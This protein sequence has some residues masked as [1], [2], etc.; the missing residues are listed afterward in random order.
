MSKL[1]KSPKKYNPKRKIIKNTDFFKPFNINIKNINLNNVKDLT[2]YESYEMEFVL[3]RYN[4]A[5]KNVIDKKEF[6][7]FLC[8]ME[9]FNWNAKNKKTQ[10]KKHQDRIYI[11]K[12]GNIFRVYL[13][14]LCSIL[15]T[16]LSLLGVQYSDNEYYEEFQFKGGF[17]VD[18]PIFM[19]LIAAF[20]TPKLKFVRELLQ[21]RA[22]SELPINYM[23]YPFAITKTED[24]HFYCN[25]SSEILDDTKNRYTFVQSLIRYPDTYHFVFLFIDHKERIVEFYDPYMS[26]NTKKQIEFTYTCLRKLFPAYRINEFW[27]LKSIQNV[28]EIEK[29]DYAYCVIWGTMLIHLKLLNMNKPIGEIEKS[30]L[31]H[32]KKD[33]LSIYE[34][35]L[36]Y[37]HFMRRII[38]ED[39]YKFYLLE[40]VFLETGR[41]E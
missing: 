27:K 25:Y 24:N 20:Q 29:D 23:Y 17:M 19:D 37:T 26:T 41:F 5:H 18:R 36:N 2:L 6:V 39:P 9:L 11:I 7:N 1:S 13:Q 38:P 8:D 33:N 12:Y 35:M 15:A 4:H 32:C 28:E 10:L 22:E 40:N 16:N 21:Y 34:V 14:Y 31:E 30:L 3:S